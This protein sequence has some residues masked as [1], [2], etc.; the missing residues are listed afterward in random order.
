MEVLRSVLVISLLGYTSAWYM[1]DRG[2]FP[3]NNAAFISVLHG[4]SASG[5]Y[6]LVVSTF[7]AVPGTTDDVTVVRDVGSQLAGGASTFQLQTLASGLLWPNEIEEVPDE[8][9]GTSGLWWVACGFLVPTKND[10]YV[11]FIENGND[12]SVSPSEWY[13][14]TETSAENGVQDYFYHRS[15]FVD[16]D[17]DGLMDMIAARVNV[18]TFGDTISNL[19][20]FKQPRSNALTTKWTERILFEGP[21]SMFRYKEIPLQNGQNRYVILST[22]YFSEKLVIS[23]ADGSSF[24]QATGSGYLFN[25][26]TIASVAGERY[27]DSEIVDLNGD[28]ELDLLVTANSD[29]NGK[30]LAFEVPWDSLF[31]GQF[32][33]YLISEGYAPHGVIT[34]EG[35]G[36]PGMS[37]SVFP[38][39]EQVKSKP[40]IIMTGDD[41]STVYLF[42]ANQQSNTADWTYTRNIIFQAN[43]GT[44][45]APAARDVDGDG[46]VEIFIPA[47]S[48]GAVHV[49]TYIP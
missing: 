39:T 3:L 26:R 7:N 38:S 30:L 49:M 36:S 32:T 20:F 42:E 14:V 9:F 47:Y 19:V 43:R 44:V 5:G 27:F 1:Q 12:N 41:D 13:G 18:P 33:R 22:Q 45:G 35:A 29:V 17:N 4:K 40:D 10:G 23:W 37:F 6:D 48:D 15:Y 34:G 11:A 31:T 25:H 46:N 16:V 24:A 8:V 28:G 2:S 21:D